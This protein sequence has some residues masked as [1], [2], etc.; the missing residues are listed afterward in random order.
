MKWF[1]KLFKKKKKSYPQD[2]KFKL[3]IIDEKSDL[4][5]E[6]LGITEERC[7]E[8]TELCIKAY[9]ASD[10]KTESYAM[11]VEQ[12]VHVNE[13]VMAVQIFE[14]VSYAQAKKNSLRSLMDNLFNND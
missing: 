12:C 14:K 7:R 2:N 10:I 3:C 5:H 6:V 13:V 1:R 8:L 4:I 11:V 9:D